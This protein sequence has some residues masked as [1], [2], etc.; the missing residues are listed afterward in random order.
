MRFT[1]HHAE[2][3]V[4]KDGDEC[5]EFAK[6]ACPKATPVKAWR[7]V[8]K[9]IGRAYLAQIDPFV[10]KGLKGFIKQLP[11]GGKIL[12]VGCAGGRDSR[13]FARRGFHVVGIDLV[14]E[15]LR[16]ARKKVPQARFLKMDA[17]KLKFAA[18]SFDAVW[19]N[20]VLVHVQKKDLL[21]VLK[22]FW[23]ILK[24][25]GRVHLRMKKVKGRTE[26]S[27]R[28]SLYN[29]RIF[30]RLRPKTLVL[31]RGEGRHG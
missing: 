7:G 20:A 9:K 15:F 14:D 1:P 22:S 13:F 4:C 27:E 28:L 24:P 12:D 8:Y 31:T 21:P 26:V 23:K 5:Q 3:P 30:I 16:V 19:A 29:E 17:R 18:N 10:V 11:R 2:S 6:A 25:G